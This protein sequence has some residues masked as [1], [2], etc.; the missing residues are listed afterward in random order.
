M[1]AGAQA[2]A[3]RAPLD[4][5]TVVFLNNRQLVCQAGNIS[6]SGMLL[7]PPERGQ[8]GQ[9]MRLVFALPGAGHLDA[10]ALLVREANEQ[11]RYA[12]GVQFL[13]APTHLQQLLDGYVT[14]H[15]PDRPAASP[16]RSSARAGASASPPVS[17]DATWDKRLRDVTPADDHPRLHGEYENNDPTPLRRLYRKALEDLYR[18]GKPR[19][20]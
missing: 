3:P 1:I 4:A 2:R 13:Q 12:W 7:Y 5:E 9:Y 15:A 14:D 6:R 16:P 20:R 18:K 10:D 8:V 17:R 19:P 11:Q